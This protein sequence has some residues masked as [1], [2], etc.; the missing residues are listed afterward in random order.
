MPAT[1]HRSLTLRGGIASGALLAAFISLGGCEKLSTNSGAKTMELLRS[2]SEQICVDENV[3]KTL[4]DLIVPKDADLDQSVPEED[5]SKARAAAS[6]SYDLTTLQ[7]FDKTVSKASCNTT[8]QVS[9]RGNQPARKFDVDYIVS[10]AADDANAFIVNARTTEAATFARSMV[11]GALADLATAR[12]KAEQD[13]QNA[14]ARATLLATVT[15]KW[16][17]D[18]WLAN[19]EDASGCSNDR[20]LVLKPD[21][22][23]RFSDASG[24]WALTAD[25]LHLIGTS[26]NGAFDRLLT[27]TAA[28]TVSFN[29]TS[30][31]GVTLAWRRCTQDEISGPP[32]GLPDEPENPS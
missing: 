26:S 2:G 16:L 30:D 31:A 1:R 13:T 17:A 9:G 22:T 12:Q 32:E 6:L 15:P 4:H 3:R 5:R 24:R 25:Q 20:A 7:S 19:G 29:A 23:F 18:T 11:D 10:P 27:I 14:Q 21:H 8:I 28:D